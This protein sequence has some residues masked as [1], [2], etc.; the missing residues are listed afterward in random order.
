MKFRICPNCG[1]HLDPDEKC[2]CDKEEREVQEW[3]SEKRKKA[4]AQHKALN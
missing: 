2:D 3:K 1:A 4:E